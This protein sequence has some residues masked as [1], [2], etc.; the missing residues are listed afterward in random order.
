[1]GSALNHGKGTGVAPAPVNLLDENNVYTIGESVQSL[2][3]TKS[4]PN[5]TGIE[6]KIDAATIFDT[7]EEAGIA[8]EEMIDTST[9]DLETGEP[10]K[11]V[12]D[13]CSMLVCEVELK[14]ISE[15]D[16]NITQ[17]SLVFRNP[18]TEEMKYVSEIAYFSRSVSLDPEDPKYYHY[19][20]LPGQSI[21]ARIAWLVDLEQY[22]KSEL[23]LCIDFNGDPE[24]I[25]YIKLNL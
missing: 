4:N 10:Q 6:Y 12:I 21:H 24:V 14:N 11:Q 13:E 5:N 8:L 1:M 15:D 3:R 23:Y 18:E 7:P 17:L 16:P 19:N 25:R 20:L 2:N 9:Y 22:D